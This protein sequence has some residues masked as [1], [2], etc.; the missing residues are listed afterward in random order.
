M[1][2]ITATAL[3]RPPLTMALRFLPLRWWTRPLITPVNV[4]SFTPV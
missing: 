3:P 2:V 4:A 1:T